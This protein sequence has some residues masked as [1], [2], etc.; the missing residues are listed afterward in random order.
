MRNRC[1]SL[2]R[3]PARNPHGRKVLAALV[4]HSCV[5]MMRKIEG[6]TDAFVHK[7]SGS[8]RRPWSGYCRDDPGV[9]GR[10]SRPCRESHRAVCGRR[11][12]RR[13][14]AA[15]CT[16][17]V[18]KPEAAILRRRPCRGRRQYRHRAAARSAPDGYT[19]LV[20]SSSFM[21]NPSLYA[22]PPFDALKDFTPVTRAAAT[23]NILVV[24]PSIE[25]KNMKGLIALMKSSPG[26]YTI[27]NPG[28]GTTPQLAGELLKLSYGI[29]ATSVPFGGSG[30]EIQSA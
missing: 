30:P 9:G 20:A 7:Q 1:S 10:L 16:E 27:A 28:V 24:H 21:V 5:A 17:A 3:I 12:H 8:V 26:K 29:D 22:K 25:A 18:G 13:D 23:P 14:G 6:E 19:I 4:S 15:N 2:G 11:S